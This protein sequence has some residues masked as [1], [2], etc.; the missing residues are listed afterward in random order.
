MKGQEMVCSPVPACHHDWMAAHRHPDG[1]KPCR[2]CGRLQTLENF[3]IEAPFAVRRTGKVCMSCRLDLSDRRW[4]S[5]CET[6]RPRAD[7]ARDAGKIGKRRSQC[8]VCMRG[9]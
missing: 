7:F 9:Y 1:R 4:C 5:G 8:R 6:Y 3:R 2:Q